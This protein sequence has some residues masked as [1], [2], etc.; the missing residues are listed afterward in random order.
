MKNLTRQI[1]DYMNANPNLV[2][3]KRGYKELEEIYKNLS[4]GSL[5]V[6]K[7]RSQFAGIRAEMQAMGLE[8]ETLGQRV[9]KL[10]GDHFNT[11]LALAGLNALRLGMQQVLT[12]VR[13]VDSAMTELRKVYDASASDYA[14]F[15]DRAAESSQRLGTSLSDNIRATAEAV[16]LGYDI[17]EAENLAESALVYLNVGDGVENVDEASASLIST[18]KAFNIEAENSIGIIDQYNEVGN[19]F[20][21]GSSDIG[22]ALQRSASALEFGNNTLEESIGLITAGLTTQPLLLATME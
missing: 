4:T 2:N 10:F 21:I 13:D 14:A 3:N 11:A 16:K 6:S 17:D 15:M 20:S 8:T 7:A 5:D 1:S 9:R 19:K 12:A 18:M 22:E